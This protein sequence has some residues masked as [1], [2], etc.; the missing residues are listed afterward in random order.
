[1]SEE[2][3]LA[4]FQA[5]ALL[6]PR[7]LAI[8]VGANIGDWSRWMARHFEQV[9]ALEPDPRAVASF[10]RSGVPTNCILLPVAVGGG[11]RTAEYCLRDDHRQSSLDESHPIG[12]GDQQAVEVVERRRTAVVTLDVIADLFPADEIDFVKIDV[13]GA[14]AQVLDGIQSDRFRRARFI[15]E[16]H[17]RDREVGL[18]LERLGYDKLLIKQHPYD[19]AHANHKWIFLPPLEQGS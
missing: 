8:D 3:W 14:E 12:G 13:E 2:W 11:R 19:S 6:G 10:R 15:I 18:E 17:D 16:M 4:E 5:R 9:V 1:M 7:R